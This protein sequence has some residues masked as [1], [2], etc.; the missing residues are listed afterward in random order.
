MI[1]AFKYDVF[2]N[3]SL[4]DRK[5]VC[6]I[7]ERLRAD[8]LRVWFDEWEI[9]PGGNIPALIKEGVENSRVLVLCMSANAF[10]SDWAKLESYTFRFRDPLNKEL[11]FIPLRLDD[12]PIKGSLAQFSYIKWLPE[13][14]EREYAKLLE[15]CRHDE[16]GIDIQK[17]AE[18]GWSLARPEEIVIDRDTRHDFCTGVKD[19]LARRVGMMCSNPA[20]RRMTSGPHSDPNKALNIGVAAH[21]TAA[22]KNG[23]RYDHSLSK[24]QRSA[25]ENGIWLCQNC[26]KLVDNDESRYPVATLNEWKKQAED[27]ALYQ[28]EANKTPPLTE[29]SLTTTSV[30]ILPTSPLLKSRIEEARSATDKHDEENAIRLWEEVRK[31]AE[32]ESN[33]AAEIC[34]RLEI[35]RLRLRGGSDLDDVL[36]ALDEC[37]RDAESVDLGN[38]RPRLLQLL[39]EAHRLKGDFDQARGFVT[40]ALEH[41]RFLGSKLDEGYALLALSALEKTKEERA[42]SA[43]ALGFIQE[44]YDCFSSVYLSGNQEKQHKAKMGFAEC[45]SW[46]ARLFDNLQLDDAMAEYARALDV[47]CEMGEEH[48][49]DVANI[50]L[51]RGE[52]HGRADDP[53]LGCEDLVAAAALFNRLGDHIK[54]AEATLGIA[55][56]LDRRG[57]RLDSKPYYATAAALATQQG[58]SKRAAWVCFRYACKLVELREFQ[59]AESIFSMLL[60]ADWLASSQRLDVLKNLCLIAQATGQEVDLARHS[61]ATLDI[62]D[63]Q[64]ATATSADARRKLIISKGKSLEDL[65]EHDRAVACWH[66]AIKGFEAANDTQG[67]IGCWFNIGGVMRKMNKPKEEREAYEKVLSLA[68]DKGDTFFL[69]MTLTMLAQLDILEQRFEEA[70]KHLD[71]AEQENGELNNPAVVLVG[72]DLRSKLPPD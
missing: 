53:Q 4:M 39:G 59:E 44:A 69:P 23:P 64:I 71:Q 14:R 58:I 38:D 25:I 66:R 18:C 19:T 50:L 51:Q 47:L 70:R 41:S 48:K 35:W 1:G 11:R 8:G 61:K 52:L 7:A 33:T 21:V 26:A 9:K 30:Q 56:L 20:C 46:R 32:E 34:A 17:Q 43:V 49:W 13:D 63:D 67:I 54:A 31:L 29:D 62:I 42:V 65:G 12:T 68:G 6:A 40:S 45:H 2:L 28:I 37:I 60:Q 3:H 24:S 55:D 22:S 72:Q 5:V 36:A 15:A 27:E 16:L 57:L 10:G